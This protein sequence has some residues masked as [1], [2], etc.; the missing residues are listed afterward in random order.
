MKVRLGPCAL[1]LGGLALAGS[2]GR[3]FLARGPETRELEREVQSIDT[4]L[5]RVRGTLAFAENDVASCQQRLESARRDS[6]AAEAEVQSVLFSDPRLAAGVDSA[7][8]DL[9]GQIAALEAEIETAHR[10]D[11]AGAPLTPPPEPAQPARV[12]DQKVRRSDAAPRDLDQRLGR[13]Q[14][15]IALVVSSRGQLATGLVVGAQDDKVYVLT[16]SAAVAPGGDV[17]CLFRASAK[18]DEFQPVPSEV[19]YRDERSPLLLLEGTIAKLAEFAVLAESDFKGSAPSKGEAVYAV[20]AHAVGVSAFTGSVFEGIVSS[21]EE[22][23][24]DG[25]QLVRTTLPVNE[26]SPGSVVVTADGKLAGVLW[27]GARE[28]DRV[29]VVLPAAAAKPVLERLRR[30]TLAIK[31][32][33][34]SE[35][36]SGSSGDYRCEASVDLGGPLSLD[37]EVFAGPDDLVLIW[38]LPAGKLTAFR[39]GKASPVWE[40]SS[41]SWSSLAY[42]PWQPY[43][44]LSSVGSRTTVTL[45]LRSGKPGSRL[46][47]QLSD[48]FYQ[49]WGTFPAGN[50]HVLALP[51]GLS[52]ANLESGRA[53]GLW[54][55]KATL[56]AQVEDLI[57]LSTDQGGVGWLTRGELLAIFTRIDALNL[58]IEKLSR[59][60]MSDPKKTNEIYKRQ[61]QI[62]VLAEQLG[63]GIKL[64]NVPGGLGR[65]PTRPGVSFCHVPGTYVH[66]IGRN[67]WQIGPDRV[68]K[69]GRLEPLWHSAAHEDWFRAGRSAAAQPCAMA[70]PDGRYAVTATHLIDLK[71]FKAVA[72]LPFPTGPAGFTSKGEKVYAYDG[73]LRRL[74]FLRLED[75]LRGKSENTETKH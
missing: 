64:F 14:A 12:A 39:S 54:I 40:I 69:L 9:N 34:S 52:I 58:E 43:G 62:R 48:H 10:S 21:L 1:V 53:V 25:H 6:D 44:F 47:E 31:F 4:E 18:G 38:N 11:Q 33:A 45:N 17:T 3:A 65:D 66:L 16:V 70:S 29:S 5:S 30:Q 20:G 75:L 73:K 42:R 60:T 37:A 32:G 63:R 55:I 74:V 59:E 51:Q 15:S 61:A 35:G 19:V 67:V 56:M 7:L 41:V 24:I 68:A 26:G 72:E 27:Q 2:I 50:C 71:D 49:A 46:P 57:T 13:F 36:S 28:L 23:S 8:D 22:A